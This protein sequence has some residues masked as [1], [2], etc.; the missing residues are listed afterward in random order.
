MSDNKLFV[1]T[2]KESNLSGVIRNIDE[3]NVAIDW[4]NDET[5]TLTNDE[6]K[7]IKSKP[8]S[9]KYLLV[10][11]KVC[12]DSLK[13][14]YKDFIRLWFISRDGTRYQYFECRVWLC[15]IRDRFFDSFP[16]TH[17]SFGIDT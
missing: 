1:I 3:N 15:C 7:E 13:Q 6:F 8:R 16:C 2:N 4:E 10:K 9:S 17:R 5:Q 11:H 14:Q 12:N